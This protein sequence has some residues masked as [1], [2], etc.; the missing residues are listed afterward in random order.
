[1]L[2]RRPRSRSIFTAIVNQI[3]CAVKMLRLCSAWHFIV[4]KGQ[5]THYPSA[6]GL[7]QQTVL[8]S[9]TVALGQR[10]GHCADGDLMP[11]NFANGF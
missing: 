7:V 9:L 10:N 5:L 4:I 11:L 8:Q 6:G 3:T 1:M 2:I